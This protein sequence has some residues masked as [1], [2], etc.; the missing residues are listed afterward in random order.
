MHIDLTSFKSS[1]VL[2]DKLL[3]ESL[4]GFVSQLHKH[5]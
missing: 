4:N 5:Q 2:R 3:N 1:P